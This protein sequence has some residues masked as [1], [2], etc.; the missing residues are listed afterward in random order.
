MWH[1]FSHFC[2][3]ICLHGVLVSHYRYRNARSLV[4][5]DKL[6]HHQLYRQTEYHNSYQNENY[7]SFSSNIS[8]WLSRIKSFI[9][10]FDCVLIQLCSLYEI[11]ALCWWIYTIIW[12]SVMGIHH[13]PHTTNEKCFLYGYYHKKKIT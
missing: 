5:N 13:W 6:F 3:P 9:W 8:Y 1:L 12:V 4:W 10:C 2:F 11:I 7:N